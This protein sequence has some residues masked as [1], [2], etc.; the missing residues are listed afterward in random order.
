MAFFP[1]KPEYSVGIEKFDRQHKVLVGYLNE[2]YEALES[3]RGRRALAHVLN[4][5]VAY[6]HT[7]FTSEEVLMERYR[8]PGYAEHKHKHDKMTAH[9][10]MLKRKF[11]SGEITSPV[12][13]TNFLNSWLA[14]HIMG[15]DKD[16]G[17]FL[18]EKGVKPH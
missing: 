5:L 8:F 1:W 14:R 7:H 16:Y 11:D 17:P 4:G 2:L 15:T 6:T 3:G 13:I 10:R 9:V 12:Q 18:A